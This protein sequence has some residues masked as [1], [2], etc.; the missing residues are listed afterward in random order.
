VQLEK[1]QLGLKSAHIQRNTLLEQINRTIVAAPFNAIVTLKM[2]EAGSFAAPGVPLFQLT[3][4]SSLRFTI[5]VP[6]NDLNL[7][8]VNQPATIIADVYPSISSF[9]K[10]FTD[11]KQR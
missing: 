10:N 4:I 3:D 1:A 8:H 6:E 7:F 5:N 9:W 2:T 11:R